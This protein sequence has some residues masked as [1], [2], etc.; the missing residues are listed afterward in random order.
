MALGGLSVS[1]PSA[2]V[3]MNGNSGGP[4]DQ[5]YAIIGTGVDKSQVKVVVSVNECQMRCSP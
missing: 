4:D 2:V 5:Y 3:L 1:S